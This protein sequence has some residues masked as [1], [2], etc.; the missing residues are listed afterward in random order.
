MPMGE[1]WGKEE[2]KYNGLLHTN[3]NGEIIK[4]TVPTKQG[5][6]GKYYENLYSS[7][8]DGAPLQETATDGLNVIRVIEAA[9]E[10][11]KTGRKVA[12]NERSY[13]GL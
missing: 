7:I 5:N 1:D 13:K 8:R 11:Y 10:S 2:E 4:T 6:F 12:F 3:E 9:V